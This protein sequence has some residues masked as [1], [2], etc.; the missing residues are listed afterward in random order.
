M[1]S[2]Q[3]DLPSNLILTICCLT[4]ATIR[5]PSL[6]ESLADAMPLAGGGGGAFCLGGERA[7]ARWNASAAAAVLS[8]CANITVRAGD[9]LNLSWA[10][11]NP[12]AEQPSPPVRITAD[13]WGTWTDETMDKAPSALHGVAGGMHPVRVFAP[14]F[15][16]AAIWQATP[17]AGRP[18]A[19]TVQLVANIDL[20]PAPTARP[21]LRIANLS[22]PGPAGPLTLAGSL[23]DGSMAEYAFC[24]PDG[25]GRRGWVD[26]NGALN[27][28]LCDGAT[29]R[30]GVPY[31]FSF[32]LI[33]PPH[34]RAAAAAIIGAAGGPVEIPPRA[35]AA[36]N[37]SIVGV[38]GG[39]APLLV[40]V[41]CFTIR[42]AS[43]ATPLGGAANVLLLTLQTNVDLDSADASAVTL[44]GLGSLALPPPRLTQVH[45]RWDAKPS[46]SCLRT[47][48]A[49]DSP[50][51]LP[52][53]WIR[54]GFSMQMIR[55]GMNRQRC[56]LITCSAGAW[57]VG[58]AAVVRSGRWF[59]GRC[60][61]GVPCS[62]NCV[63]VGVCRAG[64][65]RRAPLCLRL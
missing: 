17:L 8:V 52:D 11:I 27:L 23:A 22:L 48:A 34:A 9:I 50:T 6:P 63:V 61:A 64:N 3:V 31:A 19:L 47:V 55:S 7:V 33:N 2:W 36:R 12:L 14:A 5:V 45:G 53:E 24:G 49:S 40:V 65:A 35:M 4:G 38:P 60:R 62:G 51:L 30:A 42:R 28:A 43:Q 46:E 44:A 56:R 20:A 25:A 32:A 1:P 54:H 15:T 41:P 10:V 26:E 58:P 18:N 16:G 59:G 39:E 21:V 37:G 29:L 57:G 13:A